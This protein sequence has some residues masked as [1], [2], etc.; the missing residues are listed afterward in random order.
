MKKMLVGGFLFLVGIIFYLAIHIPAAKYAAELGGWSTP[1]GKLGTAL[2]DMGGTAPTRYSIFFIVIGFL[3]LMYGTFENE[4]NALAV[5]LYAASR[6]AVQKW[7][8][9]Q[10]QE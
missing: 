10:S 1:P 7:K 6:K 4:V 3:L 5:K 9:R 2:R 8:E